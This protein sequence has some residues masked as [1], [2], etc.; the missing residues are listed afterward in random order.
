MSPK[1]KTIYARTFSLLILKAPARL[2]RCMMESGEFLSKN[3]ESRDPYL[4]STHTDQAHIPT[5]M[6]QHATTPAHAGDA[7]ADRGSKVHRQESDEHTAIMRSPS[8]SSCVGGATVAAPP[9][10]AFSA[11]LPEATVPQPG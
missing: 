2:G 10:V 4:A 6:Q 7:A 3:R 8:S 5:T 11:N 9:C 1:A